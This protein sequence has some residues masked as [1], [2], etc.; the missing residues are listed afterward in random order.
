MNVTQ[1]CSS[2][3]PCY[4]LTHSYCASG[5]CT[6]VTPRYYDTQWLAC[7][8]NQSLVRRMPVMILLIRIY[9]VQVVSNSFVPYGAN[10][11]KSA[12]CD[13][14]QLTACIAGRYVRK[15]AHTTMRSCLCVG[16][17]AYRTPGK[18]MQ[19]GVCVYDPTIADCRLPMVLCSDGR[20]RMSTSRSWARTAP[21]RA[22]RRQ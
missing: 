5:V 15:R 22:S 2:Y 3:N 6:C 21:A 18:C 9:H 17:T 13:P 11:S 19:P 7:R 16:V 12:V 8:L 4:P 14:S 1:N 10:C 20:R